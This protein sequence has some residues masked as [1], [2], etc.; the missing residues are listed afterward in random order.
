MQS[1]NNG[2][3]FRWLASYTKNVCICWNTCNICM[4]L[5]RCRCTWEMSTCPRKHKHENGQIVCV[6]A[7][8]IFDGNNSVLASWSTWLKC[9]FNHVQQCRGPSMVIHGW[10]LWVCNEVLWLT[11]GWTWPFMTIHR[12][13]TC[14]PITVTSVCDVVSNSLDTCTTSAIPV[15]L[16]SLSWRNMYQQKCILVCH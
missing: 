6:K 9:Y 10:G 5:N 16:H 7:W 15:Y 13:T 14:H 12:W 3:C 8:E 2:T 11:V 1:V 4:C